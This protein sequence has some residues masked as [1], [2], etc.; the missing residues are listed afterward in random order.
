MKKKLVIGLLV[1]ILLVVAFFTFVVAAIK[2]AIGVAFL[3]V[4]ALAILILW[5]MWKV[6]HE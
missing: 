2:V 3:G 5:G 6:K 4:I 1:V